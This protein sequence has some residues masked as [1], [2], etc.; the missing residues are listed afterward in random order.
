MTALQNMAL[1]DMDTRNMTAIK[2]QAVARIYIP[3]P[4]HTSLVDN[5]WLYRV[6]CASYTSL[7]TF[8]RSL[9]FLLSLHFGSENESST[10]LLNIG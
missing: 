7:A 6:L 10:F 9:L 4:M 8:R 2:Q 3:K 5:V 1:E